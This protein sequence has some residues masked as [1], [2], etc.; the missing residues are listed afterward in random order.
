[1]ASQ[2]EAGLGF[3]LSSTYPTASRWSTYPSYQVP[4]TSAF[5]PRLVKVKSRSETKAQALQSVQPLLRARQRQAKDAKRGYV[6]RAL[7]PAGRVLKQALWPPL[8]QLQPPKGNGCARYNSARPHPED[9]SQ[10]VPEKSLWA[11]D[12]WWVTSLWQASG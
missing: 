9:S 12:S 4:L 6:K 1:M 8:G 5:L 7:A 2:L 11:K 10:P 3:E